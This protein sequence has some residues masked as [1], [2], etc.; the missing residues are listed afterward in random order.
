[1]KKAIV[2]DVNYTFLGRYILKN[3]KEVYIHSAPDENWMALVY[4]D[5]SFAQGGYVS[6]IKHTPNMTAK[7]YGKHFEK[8]VDEVRILPPTGGKWL[9]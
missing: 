9:R 4:V 6:L 7:L 8:A 1:M 3:K 5:G 2:D